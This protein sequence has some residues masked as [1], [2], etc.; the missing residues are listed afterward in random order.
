MAEVRLDDIS[1]KEV[2]ILLATYNGE[3][4]IAQ[5]IDS[6]LAQ[7]YVDWTLYI[8]D[9]GSSDSTLDIVREYQSRHDNIVVLDYPSQHGPKDNFLSL[10]QR[11]EADYYFLCDQDDKWQDDKVEKELVAMIQREASSPS[12]PVLVFSDLYVADGELNVI[13]DSL[14]KMSGARPEFL[15]T[16]AESAATPF[17]TGCTMLLNRSA[18]D[19]IQYP[20]TYATMHD[21]W[22]TMC[23]LR[24]GGE[25]FPI[26]EPLI[27]YRQ[28]GG[29]TLGASNLAKSN[30]MHK[31]RNIKSVLQQDKAILRMLSALHY[32][33]F[34]KFLYYKFLYKYRCRTHPRI[35]SV[36]RK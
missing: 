8:H 22:I 16:F 20:A 23:V 19:M 14:W 35:E 32:G 11:V 27:Y 4:Y 36:A 28:H 3:K 10:L 29:N 30:F 33:S 9:D 18:R 12:R 6:L 17:V 26:F 24:E 7:S 5:Q 1:G 34:F 25:A 2:A 13:S 31:L 21:A 15:T